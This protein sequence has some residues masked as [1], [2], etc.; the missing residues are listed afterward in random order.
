MT[1]GLVPMDQPT[2]MNSNGLSAITVTSPRDEFT[3]R[4]DFTIGEAQRALL[5]QQH[6]EGYWQGALEANAEMNAEAIIFH[7]FMEA[8]LD[9]PTLTKLKKLLIDTQ[10]ADGSWT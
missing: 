3:A 10:Q 4:L 9:A 5:K 2:Q 1:N 7:R 8:E 6:A